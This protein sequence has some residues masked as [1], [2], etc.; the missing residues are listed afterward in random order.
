MFAEALCISEIED[1]N[2]DQ[3]FDHHHIEAVD[4]ISAFGSIFN[5]DQNATVMPRS[6]D[7]TGGDQDNKR[8]A[9]PRLSDAALSEC[10]E[11]IQDS[12]S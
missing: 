12:V 2:V 3:T 9:T 11:G 7:E 5:S 1:V 8:K 4:I 10:I 6:N